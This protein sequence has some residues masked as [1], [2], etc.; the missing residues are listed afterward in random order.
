MCVPRP[1]PTRLYHFTSI[2]HLEMIV[3]HGL[4][5]D[6][7]AAAAG[8]LTVAV[9]NRGIKGRRRSRTV[10]IGPGGVVA[11]YAPFYFAPRS[12]MMYAISRGNVPE[13]QDGTESLLYLGTTIDGLA[14]LGLSVVFT[15]RNAVL[16]TARY[17]QRVDD[18]DSMIDWKLMEA[19]YWANTDEEPDRR[20][21]RMAE[22]L[23][24]RCVPWQAVQYVA[25]YSPARAGEAQA[26]LI[27][28]R[29]SV[30]VGIEPD[31]YFT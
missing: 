18:L 6:T 29:Q 23:V 4:L 16:E 13:Y 21:R 19:R 12:P 26:T 28:F 10:P 27:R 5:A 17:S 2:D 9:G 30:P 8:L 3:Q 11:D 1:V 20:E 7:D 25:A 31:W 15:D 22:T 24:H 14:Q